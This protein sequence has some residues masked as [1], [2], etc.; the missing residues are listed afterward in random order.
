MA[1][2]SACTQ[3]TVSCHRPQDSTLN[4]SPCGT[5]IRAPSADTS[6]RHTTPGWAGAPPDRAAGMDTPDAPGRGARCSAAAPPSAGPSPASAGAPACVPPGDP[7]D[8][9]RGP[10]AESRTMGSSDATRPSYASA[11]AS[12]PARPPGGSRSSSGR[13][14]PMRTGAPSRDAGAQARSDFASDPRSAIEGLGQKIST[15]SSP[16]F[17]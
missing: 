13:C 9:G 5:K 3:N 2:C 7:C 14:P 6:D 10:S 12:P 15:T 17:A 1:S 16:I 4:T 8:A 11:E